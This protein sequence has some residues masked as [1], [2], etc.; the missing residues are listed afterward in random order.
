MAK[1]KIISEEKAYRRYH[2][3][4]QE[5]AEQYL[6]VNRDTLTGKPTEEAQYEYLRLRK[7]E[8]RPGEIIESVIDFGNRMYGKKLRAYKEAIEEWNPFD[9]TPKPQ[10]PH[11]DSFSRYLDQFARSQTRAYSIAVA[12]HLVKNKFKIEYEVFV[13]DKNGEKIPILDPNTHEKIPQKDPKSGDIRIDPET[14]EVMYQYKTR[15]RKRNV[16]MNDVFYM[17]QDKA[18]RF[19]WDPIRRRR[20]QLIQEGKDLAGDG[21]YNSAFR[22][23][24]RKQ[25]AREFFG[26]K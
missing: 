25:I 16:T 17:T 2:K 13:L 23:E 3:L 7:I 14:G 10:R 20:K 6:K 12:K 18:D 8:Q 11:R 21:F 4:Y 9:G 19:F 24:L 22:E 26:S 1:R 15:I 5:G